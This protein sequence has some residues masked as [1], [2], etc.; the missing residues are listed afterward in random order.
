MALKVTP[1]TRRR[2]LLAA[3]LL[4]ALAWTMTMS[5]P[6]SVAAPEGN[7]IYYSNPSHK[8]VVGRFGYDCC[9]NYIAEGVT[10]PYYECGGCFICYPPPP[11]PYQP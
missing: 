1:A 10:S 9:N 11:P 4:G 7:C 6:S 8:V 3:S 2:A 5:A